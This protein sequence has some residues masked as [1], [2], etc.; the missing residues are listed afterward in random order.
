MFLVVFVAL[1]A[2]AANALGSVLQR[3]GV[4]TVPRNERMSVRVLRRFASQRVWLLGITATLAGTALQAIALAFGPLVLVQPLLISELCFALV[5]SGLAFGSRLRTREWAAVG[6]TA[7]GVALLLV[8]LAPGGG[9]PRDAS[10]GA[11]ILGCLLTIAVVGCLVLLNH[12]DRHA[13]HA[14]YLGTAAGT[15][16]AFTAALVAAVTAALTAGGVVAALSAWQTYGLILAGPAGFFLLQQMLRAGR[17]E[18]SQPALVL[19]NPLAALGW[20][21]VVFG[22]HVRGGGWI[23]VDLL[24]LAV[25]AVATSMLA[26]SSLLNDRAAAD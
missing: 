18:A 7:A 1:L 23:T 2:A 3:V 12:R 26:R 21:V 8:A 14:V 25:I 13:H 6:A 10:I 4:R 20:G 11:W 19:S 16:F 24:A 22:E 17:L 15:W 9:S 5:L